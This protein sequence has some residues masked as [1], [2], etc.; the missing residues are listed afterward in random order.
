ME[1]VKAKEK[2]TGN[3]GQ[4]EEEIENG[5]RHEDMDRGDGETGD[6]GEGVKER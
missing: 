2:R 5:R 1:A 6:V 3:E 4:E